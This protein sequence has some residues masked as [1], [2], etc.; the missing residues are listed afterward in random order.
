M[1]VSPL[2]AG[3]GIGVL[4]VTG[5]YAA[6]APRDA[7]RSRRGY[8]NALGA[9][10]VLSAL[11]DLLPQWLSM[12]TAALDLGL[13]SLLPFLPLSPTVGGTAQAVLVEIFR[14]INILAVLLLYLKGSTLP[15]AK[16]TGP[17]SATGA[18]SSSRVETRRAR[19]A[20]PALVESEGI[21]LV[22]A[23]FGLALYNF[24]LGQARGAL[25]DANASGRTVFLALL[26]LVGALRTVAISGLVLIPEGSWRAVAAFAVVI[27]VAALPGVLWPSGR[28]TLLLGLVPVGLATVSLPIALG[29]MLRWIQK[30]IGLGWRTTAVVLAT[31][32]LTR[33]VDRLLLSLAQSTR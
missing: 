31:L 16:A 21:G 14:V 22:L 6:L 26:G 9:G 25:L 19:L 30:D 33:Q 5:M 18:A 10:I 8:L 27:G 15:A 7:D 1:P 20:L 23:G 3:V 17:T 13:G 32:F 11:V 2:L 12:S 28:D 4:L 29:R 24:W